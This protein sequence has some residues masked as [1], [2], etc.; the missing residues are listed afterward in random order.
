M[1]IYNTLTGKKEEFKPTV[2]GEVRMYVCG[3]TVYDFC[4]LGHGRGAL[5]F[6]VIR[7][8]FEYRGY[9]VTYVRNFTDVDDKI[10]NR[11]NKDNTTSEAIAEKYIEEYYKDMDAFGIR[12]ADIEPKA[13]L[14]MD[15]IIAL[16]QC[17]ITK[18]F[19]Y[20][21][22]GGDVFFEVSKFKGY[23]KLSGRTLED[24]KAG[25]RV[26]IDTRKRSPMDFALWKS[27]K[28]GEPKWKCP[29]GEGRP[30]WHIECS[31][32]SIKYLGESF[33]IHGGGKDLIFPHHENEIAQSEAC[34]GKP[35]VAYW[36]HNGFV[37]IDDK[38]MSKSDGNYFRLRDILSLYDTEAVRFFLLSTHYRSPIDFSDTQLKES[39]SGLERFYNS[40]TLA[41]EAMESIDKKVEL[42]IFS[43]KACN[44]IEDKFNIEIENTRQKFM[45]AMDD[46]FNTAL[47]IAALFDFVRNMNIF[48]KE[49]SQCEN[50]VCLL[51]K[52]INIIKECGK[53]LGL[54]QN[55][56]KYHIDSDI[57]DSLLNIIIEIRKKARINKDWA[58]SDFI[59]DKL[60]EKGIELEDVKDGTR[61]RKRS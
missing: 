32:M 5:A 15:E 49:Y 16:I 61:W 33:D 44:P 38:K 12:R 46:D 26:E 29:W 3:V 42:D 18:G 41:Y 6:E 58:T 8:Y 25:A 56:K 37:N 39:S 57:V 19:A 48:L 24:M 31:A 52:G 53:V 20:V 54:F 1:K 47:A 10:I 2:E 22:E 21:V 17:L 4:H 40:L 28:P 27:A 34:T 45:E 23:G 13:T 7:N 9:K 11:A 36:M 35:F 43:F 55:D 14:H 59:R 30:G 51:M 60:K 50:K